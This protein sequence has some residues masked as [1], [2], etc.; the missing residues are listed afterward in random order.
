[1]EFEVSGD[2]II[3]MFPC[4]SRSLNNFLSLLPD[5]A[6]ERPDSCTIVFFL[7]PT[8]TFQHGTL[9]RLLGVVSHP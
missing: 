9:I 5:A 4:T 2:Q 7:L 1:M 6:H 3:M 8:T